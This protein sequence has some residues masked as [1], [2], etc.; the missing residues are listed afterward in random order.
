MPPL[1]KNWV[2]VTFFLLGFFLFVRP[3][4]R[5]QSHPPKHNMPIMGDVGRGL[6]RCPWWSAARY[7][8]MRVMITSRETPG[9]LGSF[10]F[11]RGE[12]G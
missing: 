5:N 7:G 3:R 10:Y 8:A 4:L 2:R 9:V 1:L 11:A 12:G 6:C